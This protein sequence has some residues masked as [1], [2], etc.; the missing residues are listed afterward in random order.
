[1]SATFS[2]SHFN[3]YSISGR[4]FS[5]FGE[6]KLVALNEIGIHNV[7]SLFL[8]LAMTTDLQDLVS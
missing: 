7:V 4:I 6:S 1:M 8:T 3:Y 2:V 5:K